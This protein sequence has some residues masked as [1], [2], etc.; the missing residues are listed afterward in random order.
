MSV[1]VLVRIK[2]NDYKNHMEKISKDDDES[3]SINDLHL[4][5]P[6]HLIPCVQIVGLLNCFAY[7]AH[8]F[9]QLYRNLFLELLVFILFL[10]FKIE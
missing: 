5:F 8:F 6:W 4:L 7:L 10:F 2:K 1:I 3:P 9:L